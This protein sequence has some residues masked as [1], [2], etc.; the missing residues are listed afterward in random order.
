MNCAMTIIRFRG[1]VPPGAR[2]DPYSQPDIGPRG[3]PGRGGPRRGFG[4][5][6]PDHLPPPGYDDMFM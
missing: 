3:G 5:P 4:A 1:S 2:F 6:D